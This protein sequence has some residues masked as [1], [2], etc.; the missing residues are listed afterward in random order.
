LHRLGV[1]AG[2]VWIAAI[3][4]FLLLPIVLVVINSFNATELLTFP[5]EGFSL[6]WYRAFADSDSFVEA[7]KFSLLLAAISSVLATLIGF[8]AA[9]GIQRTLGRR[10]ELGQSLA[11]LPVMVPHVLI[12][13]SLLLALTVVPLPEAIA[14]VCGHIVIAVPFTIAAIL[15]SMDG[16]DISLEHAAMTLGASRMRAAWEVVVPLTAPGLVSAALFAFI[17]SFGDAYIALFLA[18][19]GKTTLPIEI[20]TFLQWE[21]TPVVAAITS[22]QIFMIVL[23]G[24]LIERMVGLKRILRIRD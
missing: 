12:G 13:M 18:A 22:V 2:L 7:F 14:L 21:S 4:A 23:I 16:V 6:R 19:P 24:L 17:V 8:F 10:R 1:G 20:F 11:L 15:A 3:Y 9:Y 5:P